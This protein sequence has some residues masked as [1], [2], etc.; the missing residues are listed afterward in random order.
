MFSVTNRPPLPWV[1]LSSLPSSKAN[2]PS[3]RRLRK[4]LPMALSRPV[5]RRHRYIPCRAAVSRS[6]ET[7]LRLRLLDPEDLTSVI[8]VTLF[9]KRASR[10]STKNHRSKLVSRQVR[11][12]CGGVNV[13]HD[14]KMCERKRLCF[15]IKSRGFLRR[16]KISQRSC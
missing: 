3:H 6:L 10:T 8:L 12:D 7:V 16:R 2:A 13:T 9:S 14:I 1:V 11:R 4:H 5:L 15:I